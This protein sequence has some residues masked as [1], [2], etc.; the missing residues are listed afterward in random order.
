MAENAELR[1]A[2]AEL[3]S[4]QAQLAQPAAVLH[5]VGSTDRPIWA[6]HRMAQ[7]AGGVEGIRPQEGILGPQPLPTSH[8]PAQDHGNQGPGLVGPAPHPAGDRTWERDVAGREAAGTNYRTS[9]TDTEASVVNQRNKPRGDQD[10]D[11][12]QTVQRRNRHGQ[13]QRQAA[14][15]PHPKQLLPRSSADVRQSVSRPLKRHWQLGQTQSSLRCSTWSSQ[16]HGTSCASQDGH[17]TPHSASY[18]GG[19]MLS[20]WSQV[21]P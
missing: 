5:G 7:E 16:T 1:E 14:P 18:F 13:N 2:I 8:P 17:G 11:E 21:S 12:W 6:N 3:R 15:P 10:L 9:G 4:G 19:L 20:A